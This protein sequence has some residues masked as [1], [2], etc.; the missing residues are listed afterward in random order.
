MNPVTISRFSTE[1]KH[2]NA[3]L[4]FIVQITIVTNRV[5]CNKTTFIFIFIFIL[6]T[7]KQGLF[8]YI[9]FYLFFHDIKI[10]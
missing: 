4:M 6:Y 3:I 2:T 8:I 5:F 10:T 7:I 1:Q 9:I